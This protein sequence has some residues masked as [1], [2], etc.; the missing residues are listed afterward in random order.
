MNGELAIEVV[1]VTK[2]FKVHRDKQS[3]LKEKILYGG[4][5]SQEEFIAL[6]NVSLDISKGATIGLIGVNGSGKSTLLKVISKIMYPDEGSV[7][8][9]GRVS[10]LLEL[11]AGFHPDFTGR[12]NIFM[13]GALL[14]LSKYEIQLRLDEIIDFSELGEFV[15]QPVRSYSSGMYMRLAFSVAVAVD[16]EILLIDEILAVGDA[17]FQAK[18]M[19]R[20]KQ[21]QRQNKTIVMV[22]HD[23]SAVER[24]CDVAVW[25]HN[26]RLKMVGEPVTC[27][28][29]YLDDVFR[30]SHNHV[31]MNIDRTIEENVT[32]IENMND[33]KSDSETQNELLGQRYGNKRVEITGVKLI[34]DAG[35]KLVRCG[36]ELAIEIEF[37]STELV[38]D[39]VFGFGFYAENGLHCYGTNTLIDRMGVQT[40]ST[41]HGK[42]KITIPSLFLLPGEYWIDLAIHSENGEPYDFWEHSQDIKVISNKQEVGLFRLDHTWEFAFS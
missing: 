4:R 36:A 17:A 3:T 21:L 27:V 35:D 5:T 26:S 6:Q 8:V 23:T 24:F 15:E 9:R 22:T 29:S 38:E 13:N 19:S 12:E 11:G 16:P 18:C 20:I 10:S 42:I 31:I 39:T 41:G 1:N 14:G 32:N 28:K 25:M 30:A 40:L 2:K 33:S 37:E 34:S 7:K